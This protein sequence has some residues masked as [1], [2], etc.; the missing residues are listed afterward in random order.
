M[1]SFFALYCG[2]IFE[3][4]DPLALNGGFMENAWVFLAVFRFLK[5]QSFKNFNLLSQKFL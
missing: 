2:V 4:G 1:I 5:T 3:N